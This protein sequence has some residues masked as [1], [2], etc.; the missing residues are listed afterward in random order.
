MRPLDVPPCMDLLCSSGIV[1]TNWST[2]VMSFLRLVGHLLSICFLLQCSMTPRVLKCLTK[3]KN[4]NS[5][6]TGTC[7]I[8]KAKHACQFHCYFTFWYFQKPK[9]HKDDSINN[10]GKILRIGWGLFTWFLL[11]SSDEVFS[12]CQRYLFASHCSIKANP[13]HH[14]IHSLSLFIHT[15]DSLPFCFHN[16]GEGINWRLRS[17]TTFTQSDA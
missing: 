17:V 7:P 11:N 9:Q 2:E 16:N 5:S 3:Q 4:Q 15:T 12:L 1:Q 14:V 8:H 13:Y 10:V 6:T